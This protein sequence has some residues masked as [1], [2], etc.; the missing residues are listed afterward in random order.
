MMS[1]GA[2]AQVWYQTLPWPVPL[3]VFEALDEVQSD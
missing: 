1:C 3:G 2:H